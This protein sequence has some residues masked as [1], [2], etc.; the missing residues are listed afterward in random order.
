MSSLDETALLRIRRDVGVQNTSAILRCSHSKPSRSALAHQ[1]HKWG[2]GQVGITRGASNSRKHVHVCARLKRALVCLRT[3]AA[4]TA[5]TVSPCR[6]SST[7]SVPSHTYAHG[8]MHVRMHG[9]AHKCVSTH[10]VHTH[11]SQCECICVNMHGRMRAPKHTRPQARARTCVRVHARTQPCTHA[12]MHAR[13][14]AHVRRR[15]GEC[16]GGCGSGLG[17]KGGGGDTRH[18]Y[19]P[20]FSLAYSRSVCFISGW[21]H[22]TIRVFQSGRSF[23]DVSGCFR[24]AV[25]SRDCPPAA[26]ARKPAAP[27]CA[28]AAPAPRRPARSGA[29]AR[30]TCRLARGEA[31]H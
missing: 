12:A 10:C 16:W 15:A 22:T 24:T 20:P 27:A 9:H 1:K 30:R 13:T 23:Q 5:G 11:R 6:A 28:G 17:R 3:S 19:L 31:R 7:T 4:R 21:R 18:G 8:H 14:C 2:S 25:N 26:K 29:A